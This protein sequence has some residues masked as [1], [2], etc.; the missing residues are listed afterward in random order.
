MTAPAPLTSVPDVF[1]AGTTLSVLFVNASYP[2]DDGWTM[3][4]ALAGKSQ[5]HADG[6]ASGKDF[7]A[8]VDATASALIAPGLYGWQA[9]YAKTGVGTFLGASG[10][11]LVTINLAGAGPGDAQDP[12]EKELALVRQKITDIL[13][14]GVESWQLEGEAAVKLKLDQLQAREK[15]LRARLLQKRRTSAGGFFAGGVRM[16]PTRGDDCT[17][18]PIR[19]TD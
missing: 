4:L 18:P 15:V 7:V 9:L 13:T 14:S 17:L 19:V 1:V 2:A 5:T 8:T 6:V 12:D 16:L 10:D 11:V 3:K